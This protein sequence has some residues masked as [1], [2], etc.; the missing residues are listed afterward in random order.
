M[1]AVVI[2]TSLGA[3]PCSHVVSAETSALHLRAKAQGIGWF[4]SGAGNSI[5]GFVLPYIFNPDQGNLRAKTGFVFAGLCLFATVVTFFEV[6]EM[7]GRT[8]GEIDRMFELGLSARQFRT[9]HNPSA[10]LNDGEGEKQDGSREPVTP[11]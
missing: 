3:W 9:W 2:T 11:V 7:K 5:F 6:P 4:T 8:P 1:I 10:N